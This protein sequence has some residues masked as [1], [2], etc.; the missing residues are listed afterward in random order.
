MTHSILRMG[1]LNRNSGT[2]PL[3]KLL[4]ASLQVLSNCEATNIVSIIEQPIWEEQM[5]VL[6][7]RRVQVNIH[8]LSQ[9]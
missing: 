2:D 4:L 1:R 8:P 3:K 7:Q 5:K 6:C 9:P